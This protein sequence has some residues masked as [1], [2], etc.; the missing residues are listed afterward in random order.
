MAKIQMRIPATEN[1]FAG[2]QYLILD[3]NTVLRTS[4]IIPG[5]P[6]ITGKIRTA[7]LGLLTTYDS[8]NNNYYPTQ[9]LWFEAKWMDYGD[10][11]GGDNEYNKTIVFINRYQP[12]QED[13]TLALR[14]R[15]E[16][17]GGD[18]PFFDLP[19]LQMGGFARDRYR[20]QHTI[21]FHAEARYKFKPRWGLVGF[22]E[23]GW[24]NGDFSQLLSGKRI[25]SYGAGLRWQVT[26]RQQMHLGLDAAFSTDD[27]AIYVQ[28]GERF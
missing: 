21:S 25:T 7:G 19:T 15:L 18:V 10:I 24:F 20:D 28:I 16:S 2:L 14:S 1:W 11:W 12:L 3:S 27:Q 9:G 4:S 22:Y 13:L 26:K 6:D 17:S 8:R 23:F 5:A